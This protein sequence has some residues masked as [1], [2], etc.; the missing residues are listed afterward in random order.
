MVEKIGHM[1][2]QIGFMLKLCKKL[3]CGSNMKIQRT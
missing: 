2:F 3:L 1:T